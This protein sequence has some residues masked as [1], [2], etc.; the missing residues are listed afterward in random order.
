M[1]LRT[2]DLNLLVVLEA[3]L[4]EKSVTR[5]A[6]RS[7]VSQ[8]AMSQ[9]LSKLRKLLGDALLVRHGNRLLPTP[10]AEE[11]MPPLRRLLADTRA[12]LTRRQDYDPLTSKRSF[13]IAMTDHVGWLVLPRLMKSVS[14]KS[15]E[16]SLELYSPQIKQTDRELDQGNYDLILGYIPDNPGIKRECLFRDRFVTLLSSS[17][18]WL[19]DPSI[20]GFCRY[21]HIVM[22]PHGGGK[23][24]VD[25]ALKEHQL[26]RRIAL[27]IPNF[28]LGPITLQQTDYLM[29][30]PHLLAEQYAQTFGLT[31]VEVPVPIRPFDISM[32]WAPRYSQEPGL[33]WMR[34]LL[35]DAASTQAKALTSN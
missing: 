13:R 1:D 25:Y 18:P 3:L 31:W 27:R 28:A 33:I 17:H 20:E 19:K 26:E 14:E 12:L 32:A 30:L 9:S 7:H 22:S 16:C 35:K 15:P 5:A 21:G 4:E 29:T 11:L 24:A 34:E 6:A 2:L 23:G 8:S 10:F